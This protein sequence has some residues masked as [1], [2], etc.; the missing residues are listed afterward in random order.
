VAIELTKDEVKE[1][2]D[3]GITLIKKV[4]TKTIYANRLGST[5]THS[6][7]ARQFLSSIPEREDTRMS[8]FC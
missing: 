3:K 1:K 8:L 4:N 5:H 6:K 2:A 7:G